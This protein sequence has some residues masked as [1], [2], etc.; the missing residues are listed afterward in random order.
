V[1]LARG[2]EHHEAV[3]VHRRI[4]GVP[5]LRRRGGVLR[6]GDPADVVAA[7]V[8]AHRADVEPGEPAFVGGAGSGRTV[9]G[10][11]VLPLASGQFHH[12]AGERDGRGRIAAVAPHRRQRRP[13]IGREVAGVP[14][15]VG[16]QQ[17]RPPLGVEGMADHGGQRETGLVERGQCRGAGRGDQRACALGGTGLPTAGFGRAHGP[18]REAHW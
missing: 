10:Q 4:G 11:R 16:G 9:G 15:Q 7:V 17:Q 6:R 13:G 2:V 3:A 8:V 18:S 1:T 14:G 5:G 12:L